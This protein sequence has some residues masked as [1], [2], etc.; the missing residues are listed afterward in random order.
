MN[1]GVP[2]KGS[3]NGIA[4][5]VCNVLPYA[6][7][8]YDVF[9]G[10][11]AITH[12]AYLKKQFRNLVINDVEDIPFLFTEALQGK[13]WPREWIGREEFKKRRDSD[14]MVRF[15]WSFGNNGKNYLYAKEIE[16]WKKALHYARALGD[17]SL[18]LAMGID[19]DGNRA[20]I[21]AHKEQYKL[22]YM[23]W[24]L[25]E[26]GYSA[27]DVALLKQDL[28]AKIE[29]QKE[30]LRQYLL[31]G[32]KKSGLT[33]SEVNRR[34]GNQMSGHY[35]SKSQWAFPTEEQYNLMC[36][37]IPYD[38]SYMEIIGIA[39]LYESLQSLERL[40]S[41]ESLERL[42][43]L[44]RPES[45]Q[46]LESLESLER[47]ESLQRLQRL[48][49]LES[50][51]GITITAIQGDYQNLKFDDPDGV[52]YC[53]PPYK[54]TDGYGTKKGAKFNHE[55]FYDWCER[56]TLPVYISEY[57]MPEDRFVCV[58]QFEKQ[59]KLS[60]TG[61]KKVIEK[62]FRPKRQVNAN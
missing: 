19:S 9:A 47:L 41:L 42:E 43:R 46:S 48:E 30:E 7:T 6:N 15:L 44:Q 52:I 38:K 50:A 60:C 62:I 17:K 39:K 54:N 27:D 11:C 34:L 33:Q 14:P 58:A 61:S 20:D 37:F 18:L 53:D 12:C 57:S 21:K 59:S 35:F 22:K 1:F 23:T 2:Y 4:V 28:K 29:I 10:G 25:K 31:D 16:P 24:Y 36:A 3:K 5:K 45:L 13:K 8:L 49:R 55:A 40:Q 32:L 26:N 51:D 56:Q